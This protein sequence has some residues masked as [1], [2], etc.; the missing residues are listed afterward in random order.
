MTTGAC[1]TVTVSH[2]LQRDFVQVRF[3]YQNLALSSFPIPGLHSIL[4]FPGEVSVCTCWNLGP[5]YWEYLCTVFSSGSFHESIL[6]N[7]M[8]ESHGILFNILW[9]PRLLLS[10]DWE[11][12]VSTQSTLPLPMWILTRT[13]VFR[14]VNQLYGPQPT[15]IQ[16]LLL[17]APH[18]KSDTG[19]INVLV[20]RHC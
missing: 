1:V 20:N 14:N 15:Q 11:F 5:R 18:Y 12:D 13:C 3:P 10:K 19:N 9:D 7:P 8:P 16:E 17:I 4:Q 6:S 2:K